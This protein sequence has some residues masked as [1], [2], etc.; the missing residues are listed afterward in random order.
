MT[1]RWALTMVVVLG[2]TLFSAPVHAQNC[3]Q[4]LARQDAALRQFEAD[5]RREGVEFLLDDAGHAALGEAGKRLRGDATAEAARAIR[6]RWDEYRQY[7]DQ[8]RTFQALAARLGQCLQRAE[9]GCVDEIK[10]MARGHLEAGRL[11]ARIAQAT[12]AWIDSLGNEALSRAVERVE[13]AR[14][15]MENFT[16][17]AAGTA[18][19]AA[20][21]GIG[22]CLRDF[23]RRVQQAQNS[24]TL[25]DPRQPAA[26]AGATAPR[27][28][29]MSAGTTLAVI[30]GLG[31]AAGVGLY[32]KG[33]L[34]E[35]AGAAG[36]GGSPS[37]SSQIQ[38]VSASPIRCDRVGGTQSLCRG[39][40]VLDVGN[41][42]SAGT[43]VCIRTDPSAFVDC[44]IKGST[45]S[46]SF[47]IEERIVN[48]D[49][50]GNI[51]GC[52]PS[53]TGI[54]VYQGSPNNVAA[55]ARVGA[56]IQVSCH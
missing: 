19:T 39:T 45:G 13:R 14:S 10:A 17:R 31:A 34:D 1:G 36:G 33:A 6:A 9:S 25:V 56:S 49:L 41:V 42:F 35:A 27:K 7:V 44:R 15:L 28:R 5:V 26:P 23:D 16:N 3:E 55:T 48:V 52:R 11:S 18:T 47:T 40:I 2:S 54:F 38:L 37:G 50:N 20:A 24:S 21:Q 46:L 30:G 32:A 22:S 51:I 4:E 12:A 53:Q 8:A 43:Q 29:G